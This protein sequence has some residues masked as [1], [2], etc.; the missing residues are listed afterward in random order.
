MR[1]LCLVFSKAPCIRSSTSNRIAQS[2]TA[3]PLKYDQN[4]RRLKT[5]IETACEAC[6]DC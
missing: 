6:H 5:P 4:Q 3:D 2:A 1:L